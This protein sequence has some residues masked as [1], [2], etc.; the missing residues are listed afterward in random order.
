MVRILSAD[1]EHLSRVFSFFKAIVIC[2]LISI[3]F[4]VGPLVESMVIVI[5]VQLLYLELSYFTLRQIFDPSY[6]IINCSI[7]G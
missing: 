2:L 1:E 6:I 4:R 7:V 3:V 5:Y